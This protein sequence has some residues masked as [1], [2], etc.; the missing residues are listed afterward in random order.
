[1]R[2]YNLYYRYINKEMK[3]TLTCKHMTLL[4]LKEV[5]LNYLRAL[6]GNELENELLELKYKERYT[7]NTAHEVVQLVLG[8]ISFLA[9]ILVIGLGIADFTK[10]TW[11]YFF[12]VFAFVYMIPFLLAVALNVERSITH[13]RKSNKIEFEHFKRD[14]IEEVLSKRGSRKAPVK[15]VVRS[16]G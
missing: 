11:M 5:Y 7:D 2:C 1:M 8:F 16:N 9:S 4:E 12:K 10:E 6:P 14:C 3:Q 15:R 13:F